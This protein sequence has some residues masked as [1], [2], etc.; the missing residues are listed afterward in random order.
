MFSL[1]LI[2]MLT[3]SDEKTKL[4]VGGGKYY[5]EDKKNNENLS[6]MYSMSGSIHHIYSSSARLLDLSPRPLLLS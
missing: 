6:E 4:K 3:F 5:L 1:F 2:F